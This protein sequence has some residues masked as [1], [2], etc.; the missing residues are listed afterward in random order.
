MSEPLDAVN[1]ARRIRIVLEVAAHRIDVCDR[2]HQEIT[3]NVLVPVD[4]VTKEDAAKVR[5]ERR[6]L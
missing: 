5:Y 3:G 6:R 1:M 2:C 4:A